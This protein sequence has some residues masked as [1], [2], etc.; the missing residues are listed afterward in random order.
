V[1]QAFQDVQEF[2]QAAGQPWGGEPSTPAI[3][4]DPVLH[5]L[6]DLA[7]ELAA[8]CQRLKPFASPA[9][10]RVRLMAEELGEVVEA[11][12]RGDVVAYTDGLADLSYVT[13]G[14]AVQCGIP[15]AEAWT[16]VQRANISKFP[17]CR[18]CGGD[19]HYADEAGSDLPNN[20][21]ASCD[22]R[23]RTVL[24]DANGKVLKPPGW[25]P[26]DIAGVLARARGG[27]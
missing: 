25:T 6:H 24:R 21:C 27:L 3:G 26:P 10:L 18:N 23:G 9:A 7:V 20:D 1:K 11:I 2:H 4:S 17:I 14:S 15:L 22:G 5:E 12:I 19:G 13:I 16:E 8:T